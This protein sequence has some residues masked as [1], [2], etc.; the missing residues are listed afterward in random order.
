MNE[1][2]ANLPSATE[3]D[4]TLPLSGT[5][6]AATSTPE[7][8]PA[9]PSS[10]AL[11]LLTTIKHTIKA[12]THLSN[13]DIAIAAFWVISTW[14][15]EALIVLP[16]LVITG[17]AHEATELLRVLHDLCLGSLLLAGFRRGDLK[18]VSRHTLL[19][20]EPNLNNQTAALLGNLTNRG[21]MIVEQ[22]SYLQCHSSK[23]VYIG[24]DPTIR[25]IQHAIYID[26]TPALNAEKRIPPVGIDQAVEDLNSNLAKYREGHL[27]QVRRLAFNPIGVSPET[28]AVA[29]ALGSCIVDSPDLQAALVAILAPWDRRQI[30]E[31]RNTT[32]ALVVEA[33]LALSTG[34]T[35]QLYAR[36]IAVEINRL[37]EARGEPSKLSPEKV[38]HRLRKLGLPTR[39]LSQAGNGLIMDKETLTRLQTLSAM[40]VGEDRL[41]DTENLHCSQ[42]TAGKTVVEVM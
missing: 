22:G 31:R 3:A 6:K 15:Q 5:N 32:E 10:K 12:Q 28:C 33:I 37:V 40:Y 13:A 29:K 7:S 11:E 34:G 17:P 30:S 23:A 25:R 1:S 35:E 4:P 36:E 41:A 24:E 18:D 39:R 8:S 16:C 38:G 21:F 42:A 27:A 20:S 2:Q 19:I 14:F 9:P 26:V